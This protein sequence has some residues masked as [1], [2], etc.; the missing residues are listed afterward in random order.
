MFMHRSLNRC[1]NCR[2]VKKFTYFRSSIREKSFVNSLRHLMLKGKGCGDVYECWQNSRKLLRIY[3][4]FYF[5]ENHNIFSLEA[6]QRY[7][8]QAWI[9]GLYVSKVF[10]YVI[11][12]VPNCVMYQIR[13][14]FFDFTFHKINQQKIINFCNQFF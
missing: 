5:E 3:S 6:I 12:N 13:Q 11:K 8:Q 2:I 1:Y 9:F 10:F 14:T 7:K 4:V